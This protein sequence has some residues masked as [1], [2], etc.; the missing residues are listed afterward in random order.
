MS[1]GREDVVWNRVKVPGHVTMRIGTK[2]Q[3]VL[4]YMLLILN[5]PCYAIHCTFDRTISDRAVTELTG[6]CEKNKYMLLHTDKYNAS[7]T[8]YWY[9]D[10]VND[11]SLNTT[12][13]FSTKARTAFMY[14]MPLPPDDEVQFEYAELC[15]CTCGK[16]L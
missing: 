9:V 8:G 2:A 13:A 16:D 12:M 4:L 14:G 1:E 3:V 5:T 11:S 15:T 6:V 7:L 10:V